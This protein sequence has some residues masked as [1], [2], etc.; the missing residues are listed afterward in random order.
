MRECKKCSGVIAWSR[1]DKIKYLDR[2]VAVTK[3]SESKELCSKCYDKGG[4]K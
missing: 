3:E 4:F 2:M 1:G